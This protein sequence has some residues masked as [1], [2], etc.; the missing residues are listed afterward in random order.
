MQKTS[1]ITVN[2]NI[3]KSHA[4]RSRYSCARTEENTETHS[5]IFLSLQ[6]TPSGIWQ[7]IEHCQHLV[8]G[9]LYHLLWLLPAELFHGCVIVFLALCEEHFQHPTFILQAHKDTLQLQTVPGLMIQRFSYISPNI[10]QGSF[11]L[12]LSKKGRSSYFQALSIYIYVCVYVEDDYEEF[13][14]LNLMICVKRHRIIFKVLVS[15]FIIAS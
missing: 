1:N 14:L 9:P 12:L 15:E 2:M 4:D 6:H 7:V 8:H 10:R 3:R 5:D 13:W 11:Q